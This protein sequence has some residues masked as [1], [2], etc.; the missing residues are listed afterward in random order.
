[1]RPPVM[2][3]H[4]SAASR[5]VDRRSFSGPPLDDTSAPDWDDLQLAVDSITMGRPIQRCS[6]PRLIGASARYMVITRR[7]RPRV[8]G[9]RGW[10]VSHSPSVTGL[11]LRQV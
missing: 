8:G 9:H 1:M 10:A 2:L 5:T 7:T 4:R 6:S 3:T 11:F